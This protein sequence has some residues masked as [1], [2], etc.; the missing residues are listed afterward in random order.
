VPEPLSI[1][2]VLE[3]NRCITGSVVQ[4][5]EAARGLAARGHHI[6]V[7]SRAGGDLESACA[8]AGVRFLPLPLRSSVDVRSARTL[9]HHLHDRPTDIVHVHKGR[10][11]SVALLAAFGLGPR[12]ALVVNR[13]VS[14]PLDRFNR[15]KFRHSRVRAVVCVADAVRSTVIDTG[16]L[17]PSL[18]HTVYGGTDADRFDP[19]R[20]DGAAVRGGL[21]LSSGHTLIGQVSVRD[22]KG[23]RELMEAFALLHSAHP[24]TRLLMVGCEPGRG[25][26]EVVV[27]ATEF[28]VND[29]VLTLPYR[30]D[31]PHVLAACDV[32]VDASWSGT[33]ITGTVREAMALGR[34]VVATDCGGNRELVVDG[35]VGLL[36]SPRDVEAL[37][38]AL[39]RLLDEP[40]LR[41]RLGRAAR[42][43]VLDRFTTEHRVDRL[44]VLYQNVLRGCGD[45][46]LRE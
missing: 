1:L 39:E 30:S 14:F 5:V 18:V 3:K 19:E 20:I 40:G 10:S 22:W 4:M 29:A 11:H 43:R 35:E 46:G 13:G 23:W 37:A 2:H 38:A 21:G 24:T 28:G 15:W 32:V 34:A 45:E 8:A 41:D 27:T 44:E 16:R 33:G 25:H 31:M 42:Q 7:A 36:V 9:R 6:G 12:P 17:D 26:D